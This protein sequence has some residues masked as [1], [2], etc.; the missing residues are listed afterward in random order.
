MTRRGGN[1]Q[2][3]ETVPTRRGVSVHGLGQCQQGD[4]ATTGGGQIG[5]RMQRRAG[6][7]LAEGDVRDSTQLCCALCHGGDNSSTGSGRPPRKLSGEGLSPTA[8]LYLIDSTRLARLKP[9]SLGVARPTNKKFRE[10][11]LDDTTSQTTGDG[12]MDFPTNRERNRL[13]ID[14]VG[15]AGAGYPPHN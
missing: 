9:A 13:R 14:R 8:F 2:A 11:W 15:G 3:T 6:W 4:G 7:T 12:S 5:K 10:S 1:S